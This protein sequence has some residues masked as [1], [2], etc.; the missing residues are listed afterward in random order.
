MLPVVATMAEAVVDT[1]AAVADI[2][3]VLEE[4]KR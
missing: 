1:P 2:D 4:A 3:N